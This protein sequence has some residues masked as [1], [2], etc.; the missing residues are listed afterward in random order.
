M[1]HL[2]FSQA[3]ILRHE[4]SKPELAKK[5]EEWIIAIHLDGF[6]GAGKTISS[7]SLA[8]CCFSGGHPD[9]SVGQ[10]AC[11]PTPASDTHS[12]GSCQLVRGSWAVLVWMVNPLPDISSQGAS[13]TP[14]VTPPLTPETSLDVL[15]QSQQ[16][17]EPPHLLLLGSTCGSGK[18][19]IAVS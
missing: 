7:W 4:E 9:T 18:Y 12:R 6:R 13:M 16:L 5:G 1:S 19:P 3:S 2:I 17:Q 10:G 8:H 14:P 15:E 11:M